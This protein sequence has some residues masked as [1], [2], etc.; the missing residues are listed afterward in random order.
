MQDHDQP[1][2]A[3][4]SS[5][6]RRDQIAASSFWLFE[7]R[8]YR[9]QAGAAAIA[10]VFD[11]RALGKYPDTGPQDIS[12]QKSKVRKKAREPEFAGFSCESW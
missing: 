9:H 1:T 8:M 2:S 4:R 3:G 12:L 6:R 7:C 5:Q 10:D 11:C